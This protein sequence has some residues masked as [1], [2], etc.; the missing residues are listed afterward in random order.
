MPDRGVP[1]LTNVYDA[2]CE[3]RL[4]S[5]DTRLVLRLSELSDVSRLVLQRCRSSRVSQLLGLTRTTWSALLDVHVS[6]LIQGKKNGPSRVGRLLDELAEIARTSSSSPERSGASIEA[7]APDDLSKLVDE[8]VYLMYGGTNAGFSRLVRDAQLLGTSDLAAVMKN[9]PPTKEATQVLL[10]REEGRQSAGTVFTTEEAVRRIWRGEPLRQFAEGE[11]GVSPMPDN[12]TLTSFERGVV[13]TRES[14]LESMTLA[15]IGERH[16]LTR[17]RVRQIRQR[18]RELI[19]ADLLLRERG[20]SRR[21]KLA[22]DISETILESPGVA[23][24]T[25]SEKFQ[26]STDNVGSAIPRPLRKFVDYGRR[27]RVVTASPWSDD[28]LLDALRLAGTYEFPLSGSTFNELVEVGVIFGPGSQTVS[29]RFGSWTHACELAG[30]EANE[31][32]RGDYQEKWSEDELIGM[33]VRY[34]LDPRQKS[35]PSDFD[36]WRASQDYEVASCAHI[37]NVFGTWTQLAN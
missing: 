33:I 13:M 19:P 29:K 24:D 25:L 15:E 37:R 14:V 30:V 3:R 16:G 11:C 28:A 32:V 35:G 27:N 7:L 10:R 23:L 31:P 6:D 22:H 1:D 2:V 36:D 17:E 21:E 26:L 5:I 34:L 12:S 4:Q 20:E 8:P 9:F 18:W